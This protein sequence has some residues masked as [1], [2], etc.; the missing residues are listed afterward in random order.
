M[1]AA[2]W[3]LVW[4]VVRSG[5]PPGAVG[6]VPAG[7]KKGVSWKRRGGGGSSIAGAQLE[8]RLGGN[9]L[10]ALGSPL[11]GEACTVSR[12]LCPRE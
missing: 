10:P 4:L 2:S 7:G 6:E 3:R 1:V 8:G 5:W 12:Y 9:W 11:L